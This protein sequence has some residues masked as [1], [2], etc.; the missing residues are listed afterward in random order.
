LATRLLPVTEEIPKSL[1]PIGGRPF[2]AHQLELLRSRGIE[3]VVLCIGHLG[4]LIRD[5]AGDGEAF[6]LRISYS[7]DGPQALGTAG[8][9]RKALPLLG[10]HFFV[11]YGDSYLP[12]D[13]SA[14]C[15]AFEASG[16][17]GL[18]TIYK[19]EGKYDASNVEAVNGRMVRYDK[20]DRSGAMTY[21]DYG[22]GVFDC[23]VFAEMRAGES[24]DLATVY[25]RLLKTRELAGF[26]VSERF[27]EIGSRAGIADLERHLE[28]RVR[29]RLG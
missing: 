15:S 27:Y 9:I 19:N 28:N 13:Y 24:C 29:N 21:I 6:G 10:S 17:R 11:L 14:V 16:M 22:L 1:I 12:C 23:S 4:N 25:E 20:R 7:T 5:F 18:M 2:L 8:A 3:D 26:E